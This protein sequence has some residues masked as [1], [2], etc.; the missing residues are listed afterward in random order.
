MKEPE[1]LDIKFIQKHFPETLENIRWYREALHWGV[2]KYEK[3]YLIESMKI[4][5]NAMQRDI[6][7]LL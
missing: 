5:K 3:E 1:T 2:W 4:C 7:K 6:D